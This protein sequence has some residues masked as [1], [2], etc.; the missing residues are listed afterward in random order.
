MVRGVTSLKKLWEWNGKGMHEGCG[1]SY[2]NGKG[3]G[4]YPMKKIWPKKLRI[5][6]ESEK[7]IARI[8]DEFFRCSGLLKT[9]AFRWTIQNIMTLTPPPV[10]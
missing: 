9:S 1:Q 7:V 6:S 4:N 10:F 3:T 2:E 8:I 5:A